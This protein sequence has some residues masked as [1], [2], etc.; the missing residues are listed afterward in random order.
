MRSLGT[1][2][3][4]DALARAYVVCEV[5]ACTRRRGWLNGRCGDWMHAFV[6]PNAGARGVYGGLREE[7]E[8]EEDEA[9]E[10]STWDLLERD[11]C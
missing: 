5:L 11:V 3:E 1:V 7:E 10:A 9:N 8:E 6:G 4:K 2:I